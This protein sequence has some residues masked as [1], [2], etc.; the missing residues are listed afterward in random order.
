MTVT[1]NRPPEDVFAVLSDVRNVPLW[2]P[3]TIEERMLT[4]GPMGVG[5]RRVAV[6]KGFAGRTTANEAEMVG[7]EPNR[8]MV[9]KSVRSPVPFRITIDFEPVDGDTRLRWTADIRPGGV[10]RPTGPLMA[11]LYRRVFRRDL[12][13]LRDLMNAGE[14]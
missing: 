12:R 14:L 7:F 1:I 6:I 5:S 10:L 9:V 8:R 11:A 13:R 2:S 3:N 4:D